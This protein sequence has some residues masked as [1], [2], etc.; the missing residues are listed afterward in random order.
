M[1]IGGPLLAIV[2]NE[3][4]APALLPYEEEVIAETEETIKQQ[5]EQVQ[6]LESDLQS[7]DEV[8]LRFMQAMQLEILRWKYLVQTYHS[9]RFKKIQTMMAQMIIPDPDHLSEAEAGFCRKLGD[10]IQAALEGGGLG[11][12]RESEECTGYVFF[13]ALEDLNRIVLSSV[14]THEPQD[15]R[16]GQIYFAR[17]DKVKPWLDD[18]SVMLL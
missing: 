6:K 2:S 10:A 17:F 1:S 14:E 13:K 15:V 4:C 9:T 18:R 8:Q 11:F 5:S 16:K 12:Q 3:R 7:L